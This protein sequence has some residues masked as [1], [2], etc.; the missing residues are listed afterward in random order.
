METID[1]LFLK[2]KKKKSFKNLMKHERIIKYIKGKQT[3]SS[4]IENIFLG[5]HDEIQSEWNRD[6]DFEKRHGFNTHDLFY[7]LQDFFTIQL[8]KPKK[9]INPHSGRWGEVKVHKI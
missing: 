8:K 3:Q 4:R 5:I 1:Q 6:L 2:V 9:E 7:F